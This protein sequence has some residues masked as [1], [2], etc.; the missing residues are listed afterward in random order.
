MLRVET[1]QL[2]D[3]LICRLEGRFTGQGAE[4]L[5]LLVSRW[6]A[7]LRLIIDITEMMFIDAIGEDVLSF[8][9]QLG[10]QFIAETSYSRHTCERL[11][12]PLLHKQNSSLR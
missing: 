2:D 10:A 9:K 6:D 12:L 11:S 7:K 8:V 3:A 5:R 4:Q 1:R